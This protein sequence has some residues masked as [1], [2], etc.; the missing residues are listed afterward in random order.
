MKTSCE[1]HVHTQHGMSL[2]MGLFTHSAVILLIYFSM[3]VLGV[4]RAD[5]S[6]LRMIVPEPHEEHLTLR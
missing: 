6:K 1:V 3:L 4:R 5:K 2:V